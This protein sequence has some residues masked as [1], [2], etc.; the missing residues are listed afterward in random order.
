MALEIERKFLV[1][2]DAWRES[3]G[4][5]RCLLQAYLAETGK[6]VIRV[7]LEAGVAGW[8]T[9]KSA[10]PGMTRQEFEYLIP[11][12]DAEV[13]AKLRD[14]AVL[15]KTRFL[16]PH[17]GRVWEVDVYASENEGLV[18]A[19]IELESESAAFNRPDW[20]GREVTGEGRFY[21]SRLARHPFREWETAERG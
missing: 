9:I 21:A 14:G 3:A 15:E 5:G 2:G 8:I 19:E 7:R 18:I 16:V 13:L 4:P 12:E 6:A 20:L 17:S 10:V 11:A 1:S